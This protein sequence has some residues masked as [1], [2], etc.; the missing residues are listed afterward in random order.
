MSEPT[1]PDAEMAQKA[2]ADIRAVRGQA[3]RYLR[4]RYGDDYIYRA[5]ETFENLL[6]RWIW[7]VGADAESLAEECM[8]A[9]EEHFGGEG[10]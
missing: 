2:I 6:E 3:H 4:A 5:P 8:K 10:R 7:A 1:Q 9:I